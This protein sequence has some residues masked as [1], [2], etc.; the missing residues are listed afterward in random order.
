MASNDKEYLCLFVNDCE[1]PVTVYFYHRS[2]PICLISQTSKIIGQN[3]RFLQRKRNQ[4]KYQIY[5]E[6]KEIFKLSKCSSDKYIKVGEKGK[7]DL[8]EDLSEHQHEKTI[9]IQ[10]ADFKNSTKTST[11]TRDLYTILGLN[12]VDQINK[13]L[14]EQNADIKKAFRKQI[15]KY[16]PG[17]IHKLRKQA[18]GRGVSQMLMLHTT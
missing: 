4:F 2:D 8:V 1:N 18:R 14:D 17:G 3:E 5:C 9:A 13:P 16:H 11:G 10:H 7:V 6:R 12:F 15:Q